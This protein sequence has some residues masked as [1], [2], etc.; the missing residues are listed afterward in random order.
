M[1]DLNVVFMGTPTFA[2]PILEALIESTKV[3]LVVCQ[4]DKEKDRKGK[5]I[6]PPIKKVTSKWLN[7]IA[8]KL[9][10]QTT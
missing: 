7:S 3:S 6:I 1:K 4:P 10:N 2:V 8:Y 5:I 9:L